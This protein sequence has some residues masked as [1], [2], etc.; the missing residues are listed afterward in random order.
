MCDEIDVARK[1]L[2]ALCM[3]M[4]FLTIVYMAVYA[5]REGV[6]FNTVGGL[7][8]VYRRAFAREHKTL[9]W[10]V[11]IGIYGNTLILLFSFGL[12]YWGLSEGCVFKLSGRW[13]NL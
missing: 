10:V 1:L 12:Y 4:L 8:E 11:L 6:D 9:F 13:S 3:L 2:F 7:L 5:K